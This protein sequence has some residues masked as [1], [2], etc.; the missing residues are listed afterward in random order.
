M[1]ITISREHGSSG[2]RIGQLVAERL[3]VSCYYKEM[4]A[5]AAKESGLA[6]EF[7][8]DIN[9][10]ENAV[11]RELYLS[12]NVIQQAVSAQ[13]R[14]IKA[15]ADAGSCVIVGRAADYVL[16]DYDRVLRVFIHAPKEYRMKRI[17][18]MYGDTPEEAEASI[19]RSDEARASYYKNVSGAYWG[20]PHNY[21]LCID[22]SV[23]CETCAE[24]IC[25]YVRQ[26]QV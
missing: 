13:D 11:M 19:K 23:G 8:S 2:K 26:Q 21:D 6:K 10:N 9:S 4:V 17:M 16:R 15:I 22:S 20:N 3:G 12:T 25:A 5:I 14:A 18:E 7:I 1:I 24:L